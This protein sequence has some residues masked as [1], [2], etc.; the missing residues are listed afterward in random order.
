MENHINNYLG[1]SVSPT[2][3]LWFKGFLSWDVI[4]YF[5]VFSTTHRFFFFL[6]VKIQWFDSMLLGIGFGMV[7][8]HAKNF[9]K[10]A[11]KGRMEFWWHWCSQRHC[12]CLLQE[13]FHWHRLSTPEVP[14]FRI[15]GCWLL[16]S[17]GRSWR[18]NARSSFEEAGFLYQYGALELGSAFSGE[19]PLPVEHGEK[20]SWQPMLL[21][22]WMIVFCSLLPCSWGSWLH[23]QI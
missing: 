23:F 5:H 11:E 6:S 9:L 16:G 12:F 1:Y 21:G 17:R 4:E 18:W 22:R 19:P 14:H 10:R 15:S 13:Q 7:L 3:V 20:Y 2:N 8:T